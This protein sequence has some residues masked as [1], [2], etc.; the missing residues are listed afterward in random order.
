MASSRSARQPNG[1]SLCLALGLLVL[2]MLTGNSSAQ[3][4]TGF[5]SRTC[6]DVYDSVRLLGGPSWDVKVGR[7]DSTMASISRA[8]DKSAMQ[9]A[10][11]R[12]KRIG[13]SIL[14]LFF[15]DCFV[16]EGCDT[17]LPGSICCG[18]LAIVVASPADGCLCPYIRGDGCRCT[19]G[20]VAAEM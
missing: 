16:V 4:S 18:G 5:Y 2:L 3:L 11:A 6:P 15:Y 9:C 1:H 14:R 12:E 20:T 17:L 8:D 13:R 19:A 10:I 7:R